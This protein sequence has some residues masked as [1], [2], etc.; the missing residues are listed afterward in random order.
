MS[1]LIGD[2]K[3]VFPSRRLE[4]ANYSEILNSSQKEKGV[5][6]KSPVVAKFATT[7]KDGKIYNVEY[8]N[9]DV[10]KKWFAFSLLEEESFGL[11]GRVKK[12]MR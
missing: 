11:M 2:A 12:A 4:R 3:Y 7:A 1:N 9:L 5:S 6:D 8:C 10:G